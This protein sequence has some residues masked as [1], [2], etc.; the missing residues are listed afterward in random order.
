MRQGNYIKSP[1]WLERGDGNYFVV[2]SATGCSRDLTDG[3]DLDEDRDLFLSCY[4][5][6]KRLAEKGVKKSTAGISFHLTPSADGSRKSP[7]PESVVFLCSIAQNERLLCSTG[8][9]LHNVGKMLDTDRTYLFVLKLKIRRDEPDTIMAC[10]LS[11]DDAP[12]VI[13][14]AQWDVVSKPSYHSG[15]MK[16]LNLWSD[17]FA[18]TAIDELRIGDTWES[19]GRSF[20]RVMIGGGQHVPSVLVCEQISGIGGVMPACGFA[21]QSRPGGAG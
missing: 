10:A 5:H 2:P 12:Q 4:I 14:P 9:G 20:E 15:I 1:G 6:K 21:V 11:A 18:I 16:T 17:T 8:K 13:E 7:G 19:V 3:I